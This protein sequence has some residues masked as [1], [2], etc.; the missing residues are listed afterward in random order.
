MIDLSFSDLFELI[1]TSFFDDE[2]IEIFLDN[3]EFDEIKS[4]FDRLKRI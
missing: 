4:Y 3:V 2:N 1:K